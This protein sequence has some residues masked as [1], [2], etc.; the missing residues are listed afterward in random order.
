M[1][2]CLCVRRGRRSL[3]GLREGIEVRKTV[4]CS[5]IVD[6]NVVL[7]VGSVVVMVDLRLPRRAFE[8]EGQVC[9]WLPFAV[10]VSIA[11]KRMSDSGVDGVSL[12]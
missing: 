6:S 4:Y 12:C 8:P 1:W 9:R 3:Q 7:L 10:T 5:R 11:A 2:T